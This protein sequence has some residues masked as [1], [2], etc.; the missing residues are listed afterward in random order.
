MK[1]DLIILG[2]LLITISGCTKEIIQGTLEEPPSEMSVSV[3]CGKENEFC[4]GIA[5]TMCCE[6]ISCKLDGNYP[7]AGGVCIKG[8]A[9]KIVEETSEEPKQE[10]ARPVSI[11]AEIENN[12]IG[13]LAGAP[14]E[15]GTVALIEGGWVRP[16][17]GPFAWGW[18]EPHIETKRGDFDFEETDRWV[19]ES[20]MHKIT[21]L[22]TIWPYATWDQNKCHK[23]LS[24]D[25]SSEDQFYPRGE[26]DSIPR[27]RCVP[28]SF[29]D[30]KKFLSKLV[31]RYDGDGIEDMP[32]LEIP[33]KY[34]EVLN[35]PELKEP[36]LTF[37]K[38]TQEEYVQILKA[39]NE[40]I[41][42]SC[43]DCKIVQGGAA[44]NAPEML[45]YWKKIFQLGGAKYFDIANIHY[46]GSGDLSTLNVKDF[47]KIMQENG[48]DKPIWVTE[49]EYKSE[50]EVLS[51]FKGAIGAGASKVFFT[52]FT[53][54]YKG[55]PTP[56]A[57]SK[58]YENI[59][60][61]CASV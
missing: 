3:E 57:Y 31:E 40:A 42:S 9:R 2:I 38:G 39:S 49:A 46:I 52:R 14:E 58:V 45:A 43:P 20:Q 27:T 51:S 19:K 5:G 34:W 61:N 33:I 29:D 54:G 13:F 12:C 1:K 17:P 35:E 22:G 59:A 47:K 10:T 18:I 55:P 44:G 60:S 53:I 25:V 16:H 4:G 8:L 50:S 26:G 11:P 24:C 48:I 56:L 7:D 23:D 37:Y 36:F 15:A 6:G 28:C 32:S 41:R 21:I 30:Y